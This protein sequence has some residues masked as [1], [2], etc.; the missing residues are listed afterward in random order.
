MLYGYSQNFADQSKC[1]EIAL[2]Q[3]AQGSEVVFQVAGQCGLGS[4]SAAKDK[5]PGASAS[6][7][8]RPSSARTS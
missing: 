3:I 8:T 4:L 7:T 5:G 1:K 2:N 6:T